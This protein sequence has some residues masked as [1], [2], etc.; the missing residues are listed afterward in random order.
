MYVF[1]TFYGRKRILK[2]KIVVLFG[3][4]HPIHV[5]EKLLFKCLA[6]KAYCKQFDDSQ[7]IASG[8]ADQ[9]MEGR[10]YYGYMCV[11]KEAFA[12][13]IQVK[14]VQ[15]INNGT[16]LTENLKISFEKVMSE[17]SREPLDCV[18]NS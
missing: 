12:A 9:A 4:F 2:K 3:R 15:V 14:I 18:L 13:L 8:F 10:H 7:I 11:N 16:S 17:P 1:V 5:K 6:Y